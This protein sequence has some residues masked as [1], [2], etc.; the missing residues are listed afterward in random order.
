M[1]DGVT[2]WYTGFGGATR[3]YMALQGF[4]WCQRVIMAMGDART[5]CRHAWG[6]IL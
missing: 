1:L 6:E 2:G 3:L 4:T 5:D